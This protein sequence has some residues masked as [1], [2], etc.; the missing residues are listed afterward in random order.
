[1]QLKR[2]AFPTALVLLLLSNVYTFA[3]DTLANLPELS[4][5]LTSKKLVI[6]HCMTHIIRFEGHEFEDGCNPKYYPITSPIGG[7][8]QVNV[9][10]D[11]MLQHASI[12]EA[13][14]YEMRAAKRCG[15]DG[16]QF[17]YPLG[18]EALVDTVI[19]TYFRVADEK[20]IDFKFT[21]CF[22]HPNTPGLDENAKLIQFA[23][24]VN[25]IMSAVGHDNKHW[26]RT[27]DGRLIVYLWYGEQI[28]DIPTDNL[29]KP[30]AYYQA[31]AY[32]KLA[33]ACNERFAC[34]YSI[35]TQVD[36]AFLDDVLDYFPGVW[37]W[38]ESYERK[39][40]DV[41]VANYCKKRKRAYTGT[42]FPDFYTSKVLKPNDPEWHI[43]NNADAESAGLGGMQRKYMATG[44][45]Q[46]FRNLMDFAIKNDAPIVNVVTWN[47]YPE[48]HH[49]APE[50]NHNFG[51]S[52]LLN[53]YKS[54]LQGAANPYE[55]KD[56]AIAFFKKYKNGVSPK[57]YKV[58]LETIGRTLPELSPSTISSIEDSIEVVTIL[59]QPAQLVVNGEKVNV[60]AGLCSTR[61]KSQPG[62]V[63]VAIERNGVVSK[64]FITPEGITDKP[65]RTDRLT[66][67][68][69]TEE[70]DF[71]GDIFG[72]MPL[73]DI[74]QYSTKH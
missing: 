53:Y 61:F 58:S 32:R 11:S 41:M 38:T 45:S 42:V 39:G 70:K 64:S 65:Q 56:V 26:L 37:L 49:L 73:K 67:S 48:G 71:Y 74:S 1:M 47:D 50:S 40:Q 55:G 62:N 30:A 57:P 8:T 46:T 60:P 18:N 31:R 69:S 54:V 12:A 5:P 35:N 27:P 14:E 66:Y 25:D 21:F 68:Y 43:L 72:N 17:Y 22:S 52:V 15:I 29:G 3:Q 7:Y 10:A 36:K 13:V 28:A 20:N 16:F 4:M 19:K 2:L 59:P 9:M 33:G 51:F 24:R 6:A 63:S 34:M 23:I 44:L